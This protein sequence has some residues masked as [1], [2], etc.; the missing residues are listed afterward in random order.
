MALALALLPPSLL[1]RSLLLL[2]RARESGHRL[3]VSQAAERAL[4]ALPALTGLLV[5][6]CG[7]PE[8]IGAYGGVGHEAHCWGLRW[9]VAPGE[10]VGAGGGGLERLQLG[11]GEGCRLRSLNGW[12][13]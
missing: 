2:S 1:L 10:G 6:K 8:R 5:Y 9:G 11:L 13:A 3:Q 12:Y 4:R 7:L